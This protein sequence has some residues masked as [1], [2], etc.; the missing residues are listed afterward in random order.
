MT[1]IFLPLSAVAAILGMNTSDI[2]NM[3]TGQWIFWAVALPLTTIVVALCLIYAGE[4]QSFGATLSTLWSA[5]GTGIGRTGG[6]Q[7]SYQPR[8][9]SM[10]VTYAQVHSRPRADEMLVTPEET[11]R[12]R[13][14]LYAAEYTPP[15]RSHA[16][17]GGWPSV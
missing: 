8:T 9:V 4:V 11:R 2:R 15:G 7:T 16:V 13:H 17:S 12:V 10:P 5:R 3:K 14:D 1:V 6:R